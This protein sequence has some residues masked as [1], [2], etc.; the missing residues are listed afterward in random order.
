M[1]G[2]G[3]AS[4]ESGGVFYAVELRSLNNRYFKATIR[5][6]EEIAGLEA[7]LDSVLRKRLS[8]GSIT[9]VANFSDQA[10]AAA[11]EINDAALDRYLEIGERVG[12]S[13]DLGT[14]LALPGV[15]QP[16]RSAELMERARQPVR[17]LLEQAMERLIAMRRAEGDGLADELLR[18][19]RYIAERIDA[20]AERG[21]A[22]VEEYHQR[23]KSR[24]EDLI[25]RAQLNTN[26]VD[27]IKEVA[28]FAERCDIAEEVHR[29]K[30]HLDQ[31]EQII[32]RDDGEPAGRTLDFLAQ[33]LLREANTIASKSNDAVISRVIVEVKG[34]IDRIKEQVQNVE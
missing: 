4:C 34:A 26:A 13:L 22:V 7:E 25:A 24:M 27:L 1:T 30:A 5:L 29:L 2:Y 20:I 28:V 6:P 15:I 32:A 3:D 23:L 17:D 8:R 10:A 9:L 12:A 11:A 18:H 33:E 14:L 16:P 31:I 21:P 19:K